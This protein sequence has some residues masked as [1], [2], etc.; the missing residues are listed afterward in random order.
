MMKRA[1]DTFLSLAGLFLIF[2]FLSEDFHRGLQHL[3]TLLAQRPRWK[4]FA[5]PLGALLVLGATALILHTLLNFTALRF[6]YE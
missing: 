5:Y 6:S 2:I 1:L 3:K 4:L